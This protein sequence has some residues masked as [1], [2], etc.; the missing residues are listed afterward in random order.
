MSKQ[1]TMNLIKK[2]KR[3]SIYGFFIIALFPGQSLGVTLDECVN[4]ALSNNP[5]LQRQQL[6]QAAAS[7]SL[8]EIQ[9]QNYGKISAVA[10]YTHYNLP[11][12]LVPMTP[13]SIFKDPTSVATTEDLSIA[14][15]SYELPLFTGFA[16]TSSIEVATLQRQMAE[17]AFKLSREQLIYN[18]KSLYINILSLQSQVQAQSAYIKALR[19][20]YENI[21]LEEKLGK[22]ARIDKLKAAADLERAKAQKSQIVSSLTIVNATLASLLDVSELSNFQDIPISVE[23]AVSRDSTFDSQIKN[24]QRYHSAE[25]D[26]MKSE[27]LIKQSDASLYPQIG[28]NA[29]YGQ[30]FGPN[31]SSSSKPDDW[32]N[33]EVWQAGL[34]LRWDII[35]FGK[36][37]S[38]RQRAA[39]AKQQSIRNRL[40]TEL[41]L[42]RDLTEAVTRINTAI[43]DYISAKTELAMTRETESIEEIRFNKGAA[44]LNDLLQ[45][46]ARNQLA[47]SRFITAGYTYENAGF[48]LDYLLEKG[49]TK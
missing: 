28:F 20:L 32:N 29:F 12:T 40:K 41:D 6:N 38:S 8:N 44:D 21:S 35:D 42:K 46:K 10:S 31:D 22:R 49:E 17:V 30:N 5:D 7:S 33:E 48:Y 45:A 37:S 43:T 47:L 26:V 25:L 34:T 11:R 36:R 4:L 1:L 23:N 16:Q 13:A 2:I 15:I 19:Q 27:K 24:L 18:V 39:I 14:G 3:L 9:S